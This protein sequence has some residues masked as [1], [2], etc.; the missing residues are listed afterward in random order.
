[1][2]TC[3]SV[4]ENLRKRAYRVDEVAEML[5]A[6]AKTIYQWIRTGVIPARK[7][8]NHYV[9]LVDDLESLI[10]SLPPVVAASASPPEAQS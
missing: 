5:S 3:Q 7:I 9:V 10:R 6:S 8:K 2:S 4:P 1:M